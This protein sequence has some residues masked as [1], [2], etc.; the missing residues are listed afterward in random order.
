MNNTTSSSVKDIN[1]WGIKLQTEDLSDND[2]QYL[3]QINVKDVPDI[4]WISQE[5]DRI[6]DLMKLTT[7]KNFLTKI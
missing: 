1:I 3:N 2:Y 5:I 7:K 4:E 6:W